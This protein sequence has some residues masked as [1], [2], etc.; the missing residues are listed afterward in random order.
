[1]RA[2]H[3]KDLA[4]RRYSAGS[5]AKDLPQADDA[6]SARRDHKSVLHLNAGSSA[7]AKLAMQERGNN[8]KWRR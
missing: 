8:P 6:R 5:S 4:C 3:E 2:A 7:P 1:M